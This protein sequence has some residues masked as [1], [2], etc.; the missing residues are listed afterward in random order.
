MPSLLVEME[1]LLTL[2]LGWPQNVILLISAFCVAGI[3][4]KSH[5]AY[6]ILV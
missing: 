2:F 4:G 5:Y 6:P 1:V 3:T